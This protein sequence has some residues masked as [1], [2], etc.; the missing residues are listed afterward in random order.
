M[1]NSRLLVASWLV[2][3]LAVS[4]A[5]PSKA[6]Q[7]SGGSSGQQASDQAK[8]SDQLE[9]VVVTG[10]AASLRK[11]IETKR[12][13]DVVSDGIAAEDIGQFPETNLAEA[14]QHVT[15][16][17]ITRS[18][19]EG[20]NISVRGLDPKF[21]NVLFNGRQLPAGSG[22]RAFDFRTLSGDFANS[23][24]VYKSPEAS[25]LESGLAATVNVQTI[26]PL[27]YGK[28]KFAVNAQG[29]YDDQAK[30]AFRP[31]VSA[32]FT[33]AFLDNKLGLLVG[34]NYYER[35]TLDEQATSTGNL[36]QAFPY[37]GVS[38][39][40]NVIYGGLGASYNVGA[41]KRKSAIAALEFKP[42]DAL[43]I[44]LDTLVSGFI[45]KYN[46]FNGPDFW[47]GANAGASPVTSVTLD[48]N[49]SATAWSGSNVFGYATANYNEYTQNLSSTAL[50]A[51]L[52]LAS[53]KIDAEASFGYSRESFTDIYLN[54]GTL[55]GAGAS[56]AYEATDPLKPVAFQFTNGWDPVD[57]NNYQYGGLIGFWKE[58]TSDKIRNARV[59]FS[60]DLKSGWFNSLQFGINVEDR[61]LVN[62]PNFLVVPNS[63]VA[64]ILGTGANGLPDIAP[65]YFVYNNS[66]FPTLPSQ[67]LTVNLPALFAKIP[68]VPTVAANPAAPTLSSTTNVEEKSDAIYGQAH[69]AS[70]DKRWKGNLGLR[71]VRTEE[72]SAGYGPTSDSH[73]E[74]GISFGDWSNPG[75]QAISN[76]YNNV[77]PD[78]NVSYEVTKDLIA[79]VAVAR[80]MQRPDLNLLAAASSP[81]LATQPP[82]TGVWQGT[83]AQGNPNLKP[84]LSDQIDLSLE[85]YFNERSL[86]SAAAFVKRVQNFVLTNHFTETLPVTLT[87]V[88]AGTT[89]APGDI[90]P[91]DFSVSQPVNAQKTTIKGIEFGYQQSFG[92]LRSFLKDVGTQVNYTHLWAGSL[93]LQPGGTPYPLPGVSTNTYNVGLYYDNGKTDVHALYNYRSNFLVD[94]L[95]YFGDGSWTASYGQL[96]LSGGYKVNEH[97]A[98]AVSV[99]NLNNETLA[100]YNRFGINRL[101]E[102]SG[103]HYSLGVRVTF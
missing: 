60:R 25:M 41:N 50:A 81:H 92:F 76:T 49:N 34:V 22:N 21:T 84:Y 35:S 27:E 53:W 100:Q 40:M 39:P 77:L 54:T 94:A 2:V 24:E 90:V 68:L 91:A 102:L 19:G 10:Y 7:A 95:A 80:V 59:D 1:S 82:V 12:A 98:L 83:L 67:F 93:P 74:W 42:N 96:D 88:P 51:T 45:Q 63:Y 32:L 17:E 65:Y 56:L 9:E 99:I 43:E 62:K 13:S 47:P 16:V 89:S 70:D 33:G 85:W 79:R 87:S 4:L 52:S 23:V 48:A 61:T 78:F 20:R 69:F 97:V 14:L 36:T 73:I 6:D 31:N 15:G 37:N 57:P 8:K 29:I 55:P 71:L 75:F 66:A 5:S 3:A 26:R 30:G 86:L 46:N 44:R 103:R 11:A 58:P 18:Q 101:Y 28:T 38:T 72:I 64:G